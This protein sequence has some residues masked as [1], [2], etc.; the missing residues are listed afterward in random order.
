MCILLNDPLFGLIITCNIRH[1]RKFTHRIN[2]GEILGNTGTK[3]VSFSLFQDG[4]WGNILNY[5]I[6]YGGT[7][8]MISSFFG[9]CL[10]HQIVT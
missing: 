6:Y 2:K 9:F 8:F 1:C 7:F 4:A 5:L 3:L 10:S